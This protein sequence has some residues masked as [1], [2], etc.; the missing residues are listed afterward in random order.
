VV[1][2]EVVAAAACNVQVENIRFAR[3]PTADRNGLSPHHP[4]SPPTAHFRLVPLPG[5]HIVGV[6]ID[7]GSAQS[8][9]A[10]VL[11][12]TGCLPECFSGHGRC[13]NRAVATKGQRLSIQSLAAR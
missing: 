8:S 6:L 4:L 3:R 7:V 2:A 9:P 5:G 1:V 11:A 12:T 13:Q 10:M